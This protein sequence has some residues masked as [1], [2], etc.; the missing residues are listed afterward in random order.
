[1]GNDNDDEFTIDEFFDTDADEEFNEPDEL[2][3]EMNDFELVDDDELNVVLFEL[4]TNGIW[5]IWS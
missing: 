3:F 4:N 5:S 2:D 1:M